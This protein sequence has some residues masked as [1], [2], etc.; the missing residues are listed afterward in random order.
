[1]SIPSDLYGFYPYTT[2]STD[3]SLILV[4][5]FQMQFYG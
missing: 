1:M 5:E 2:N 4:W 3:L